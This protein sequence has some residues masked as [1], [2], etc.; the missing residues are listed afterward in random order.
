[1]KTVD[2]VSNLDDHRVNR[3]AAVGAPYLLESNI[4]LLPD[5]KIPNCIAATDLLGNEKKRARLI[6]EGATLHYQ[7]YPLSS[8][9][10][11]NTATAFRSPY[12]KL[13]GRTL[14]TF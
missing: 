14:S 9:V 11:G 7:R 3:A 8:A 6:G 5:D 12:S 10:D 2:H 1:M 13:K 4:K